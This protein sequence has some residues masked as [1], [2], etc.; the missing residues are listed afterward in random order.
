MAF[1]E[2]AL[3][4]SLRWLRLKYAVKARKW[5]AKAQMRISDGLLPVGQSTDKYNEN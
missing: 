2:L 4:D 3:N 1:F 5:G